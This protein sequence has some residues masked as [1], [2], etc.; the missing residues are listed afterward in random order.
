MTIVDE[1]EVSLACVAQMAVGVASAHSNLAE[2]DYAIA[3]SGIAGPGGG[4]DVNPVGSVVISV[5]A[6]D[7]VY[8]QK[9]K[10]SAKRPRQHIRDLTVAIAFDML[11]RAI[12]NLPPIADYSYIERVDAMTYNMDECI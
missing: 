8:C 12:L 4:T 7:K 5:K 10:F 3:T 11:R 2:S 9:I 6:N 1:S